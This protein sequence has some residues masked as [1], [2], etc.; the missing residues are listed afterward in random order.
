MVCVQEHFLTEQ[1]VNLLEIN[2]GVKSFVVQASSVERGRPSG[3]VAILITSTLKP[4]P[5]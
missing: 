4:F 1:A 5:L 2:D 3:G